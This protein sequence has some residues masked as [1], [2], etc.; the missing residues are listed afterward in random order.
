MDSS[1][2]HRVVLRLTQDHAPSYRCNSFWHIKTPPTA[3][4]KSQQ[5]TFHYS[6]DIEIRLNI[7]AD[8]NE[9]HATAV[10]L[11]NNQ[12]CFISQITEALMG[13][14]SVPQQIHPIC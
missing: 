8:K 7:T 12:I 13:V 2:A 11:I 1:D 14:H 4:T 9:H 6:P 3:P 10:D 5:I